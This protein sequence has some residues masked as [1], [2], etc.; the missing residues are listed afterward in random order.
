MIEYVLKERRPAV[1]LL[2]LSEPDHSQHAHGVGSAKSNGAV[3]Q[4]D[5]QFGEVLSRLERIGLEDETDVMVVSDHGHST[6]ME[7]VDIKTNVVDAGFSPLA[8]QGSVAVAEN[9][10]SVLFYVEDGARATADQLVAWLMAQPWCG[11][12]LALEA[13]GP[14]PGTLPAALVGAEGDRAPNVMMSFG[15]NSEMSNTGVPGLARSTSTPPGQGMHGSMSRQEMHNVLLARGSSFKRGVVSTTP[16]GN[17]D[18]APTVLAI[19]GVPD[20]ERMDGRPLV[21]ALDGGPDP[22]A[23]DWGSELYDAE[24]E[25]D[26][27]TYR[28]QIRVCRVG[29]TTYVDDGNASWEPR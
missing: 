4:A 26:G 1:S 24:R 19:V 12:I 2:W 17:V 20:S 29:D 27:G 18:I 28:Q 6:A 22:K 7:T 23:V 14:M 8:G 11:A 15:W 16:S 9:G 21:E 10:G 3:M 25:L 5:F 13:V